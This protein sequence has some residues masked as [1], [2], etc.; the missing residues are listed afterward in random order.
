M[1]VAGDAKIGVL[2]FHDFTDIP[3]K[4]TFTISVQ[5]PVLPN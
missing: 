4:N 1:K 3:S 2:L 5:L